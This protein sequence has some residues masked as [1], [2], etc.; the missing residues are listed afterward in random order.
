[1]YLVVLLAVA[2]LLLYRQQGINA[3]LKAELKVRDVLIQAQ[4]KNML[5]IVEWAETE[6]RLVKENTVNVVVKSKDVK[7]SGKNWEFSY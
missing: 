6:K 5:E 4:E 1:M 7:E 2:G 3:Q